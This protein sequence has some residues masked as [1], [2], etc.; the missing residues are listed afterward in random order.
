[1]YQSIFFS[2]TPIIVFTLT[3]TIF[4]TLVSL[5]RLYIGLRREV[6]KQSETFESE[7]E[8]GMGSD[9]TTEVGSTVPL[10]RLEELEKSH[11]QLE[12]SHCQLEQSQCQ[13]EE[14]VQKLSNRLGALET[15]SGKLI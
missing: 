13:L 1:M 15:Q 7:L 14:L 11:C 4:G 12:K 6:T 3:F 8:G 5:V 10:L 9:K 2:T